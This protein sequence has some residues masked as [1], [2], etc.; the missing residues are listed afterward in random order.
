MFGLQ[1]IEFLR[2]RNP[3]WPCPL[4][5]GVLKNDP[6]NGSR[7]GRAGTVTATTSPADAAA[8]AVAP[9]NDD[10]ELTEEDRA[11]EAWQ[12]NKRD[13]AEAKARADRQKRQQKQRED[14]DV[15]ANERQNKQRRASEE[16]AARA[17]ARTMHRLVVYS[18]LSSMPLLLSH[19]ES[20][21]VKE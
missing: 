18:T 14:L 20:K 10:D 16:A 15:L 17:K 2:T 8:Q 6:G 19:I 5:A 1:V 11:I 13:Q 3:W 12:K 21:R 7:P 4:T 9:E